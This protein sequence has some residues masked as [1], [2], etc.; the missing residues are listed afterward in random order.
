MA[1]LLGGRPVQ[2]RRLLTTTLG[3]EIIRGESPPYYTTSA[4]SLNFSEPVLSSKKW[5]P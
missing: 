5:G 3:G 1:G 4:K 2:A